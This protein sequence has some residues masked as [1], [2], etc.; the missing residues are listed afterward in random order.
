MAMPDPEARPRRLERFFKAWLAILIGLLV[1]TPI[2]AVAF[3][4]WLDLRAGPYRVGFGSLA[5]GT[6]TLLL[7]SLFY[8]VWFTLLA[9]PFV[10]VRNWI[11]GPRFPFLRPGYVAVTLYGAAFLALFRHG[12]FSPSDKAQL[13]IY[14]LIALIATL[15][16][17]P[18]AGR[19]G[20][21]KSGST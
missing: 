21:F 5:S 3:F 1:A 7:F 20:L 15:T 11:V 14:E 8:A 19:F 4:A 18:V 10:L 2:G 17:V 12:Q 13:V 16:Y 6:P 9:L